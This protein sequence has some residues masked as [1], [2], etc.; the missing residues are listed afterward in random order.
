MKC[1]KSQTVLEQAR[2]RMVPSHSAR[3]GFRV[4]PI[5]VR[6]RT[7]RQADMGPYEIVFHLP[8]A[9][10]CP[11]RCA[12]R[13]FVQFGAFPLYASENT[14]GDRVVLPAA[15]AGNAHRNAVVAQQSLV[16]ADG[17]G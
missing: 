4:A 2:K 11:R 8:V 10:G 13:E 14:L 15:L 3:N 17:I 7:V 5:G 16:L 9:D 12:V 6:Q 1:R